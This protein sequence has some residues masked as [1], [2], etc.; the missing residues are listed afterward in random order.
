MLSLIVDG[1]NVI[2]QV[3]ELEAHERRSLESGRNA[4]IG[5]LKLYRKFKPYKIT[6]VF[7]GVGGMSE[8]PSAY[9]EG[10]VSVC[11]SSEAHGADA[12]IKA[13]ARELGVSAI[14]VSSDRAVADF[15]RYCGCATIGATEFYERLRFA[16]LAETKGVV[17]DER[18]EAR[19]QHKRWTTYKKGS[20]KKLPKKE[21]RNK[22]KLDKL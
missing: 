18:S 5:A 20:G 11:F 3:P 17:L 8:S 10:G 7:D 4:L 1:Y 9:K 15:A 14:V 2:R 12:V 19:P 21:R 13:R 16:A 6:V 22:L